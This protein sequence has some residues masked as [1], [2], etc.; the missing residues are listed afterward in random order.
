M[1]VLGQ[2]ERP[3][4]ELLKDGPE[5]MVGGVD[6]LRMTAPGVY[7]FLDK[8]KKPLFVGA[9][10]NCLLRAASTFTER[11]AACIAVNV[12]ICP[13]HSLTAARALATLLIGR[14]R[15]PWNHG[16]SFKRGLPAGFEKTLKQRAATE[17]RKKS[18]KKKKPRDR[19]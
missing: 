11:S 7:L 5:I 16:D 1:K 9:G 13:C 15:P 3:S 2:L 14:L 4:D 6:F 12:I 10:A 18:G 8:R 19:K 17:Q